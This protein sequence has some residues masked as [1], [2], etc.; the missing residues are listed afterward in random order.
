MIVPDLT[1]EDELDVVYVGQEL[2][3]VGKW[4]VR[5]LTDGKFR[6]SGIGGIV[7]VVSSIKPIRI[8]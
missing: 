8:G 1:P 4:V 5:V 2:K 7:V 3:G 6:P